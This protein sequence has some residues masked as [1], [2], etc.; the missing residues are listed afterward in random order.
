MFGDIPSSFSNGIHCREYFRPIGYI[1]WWKN[2][3][4]WIPKPPPE[5]RKSRK[6]Y[7]LPNGLTAAPEKNTIQDLA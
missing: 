3:D 4:Y 7:L 6:I 1:F 2:F 5:A